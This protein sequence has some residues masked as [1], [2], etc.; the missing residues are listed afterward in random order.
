MTKGTGMPTA[1]KG[2][3]GF[4]DASRTKEGTGTG[5]YGQ[6][7]GRRFSISVGRYVRVFGL[8]YT[9]SWPVLMKFNYMVD[10]RNM[11]VCVPT[12]RRL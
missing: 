8:R 2:L 10:Q 5:V 6:S 4:T 11:R 1:V 3:L 12:A 9:L 7:V